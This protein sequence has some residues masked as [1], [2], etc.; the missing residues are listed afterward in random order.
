MPFTTLEFFFS[1]NEKRDKWE[2]IRLSLSIILM[3]WNIHG[4]QKDIF[5]GQ[6]ITILK[7]IMQTMQNLFSVYHFDIWK[8]SDEVRI[9]LNWKLFLLKDFNE[10][11][12]EK[13]SSTN[14]WHSGQTRTGRKSVSECKQKYF[15]NKLIKLDIRHDIEAFIVNA[16]FINNQMIRDKTI[17]LHNII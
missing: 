11:F 5:N 9:C 7:T 10:S 4:K 8:C 6:I 3:S 15:Q 17:Q 14:F 13:N 1:V 2:T 12:N 16:V